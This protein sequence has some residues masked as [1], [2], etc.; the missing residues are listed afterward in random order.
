VRQSCMKRFTTAVGIVALLALTGCSSESLA[1]A[2]APPKAPLQPS[3][4]GTQWVVDTVYTGQTVTRAPAGA[5]AHLTFDGRGGVSGSGGCNALGGRAAV[6]DHTIV[7]SQIITTMMACG[8]ERDTLER[9][10]LTVV[11]APRVE[12]VLAGEHLTLTT[13]RNALRLHKS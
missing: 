10:V 4:Y 6:T 7:F 5:R 11:N 8:G 2:P 13:A 9:A 12:Y 1:A 3:L